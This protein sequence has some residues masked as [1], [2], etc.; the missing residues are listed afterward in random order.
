MRSLKIVFVHRLVLE[1][2]HGSKLSPCFFW[3]ISWFSQMKVF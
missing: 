3:A 2:R 1:L